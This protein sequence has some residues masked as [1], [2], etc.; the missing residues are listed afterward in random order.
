MGHHGISG[1]SSEPR[2][3]RDGGVLVQKRHHRKAVQAI[4]EA[5]PALTI[6]DTV[7]VTRFLDPKNGEVVIDVMKPKDVYAEAFKNTVRLGKSHEVPNLKLALAAKFAALISRF[8]EARKKHLDASDFIAL[9]ER[10]HT[11]IGEARLR[12]LGEAVYAG[13]GEK[14]MKFVADVKA[15]RPLRV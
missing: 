3:T 7:V 4:H 9:V 11:A 2:A 8:R 14:V 6:T 10:N 12:Y 15:G 13:G 5:F 1:W